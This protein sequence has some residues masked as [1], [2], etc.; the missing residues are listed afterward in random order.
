MEDTLKLEVQL[1]LG[2]KIKTRGD[3]Q[4]LSDLIVEE[5][6]TQISYNTLRR[7]FKVD[8]QAQNKASVQTLNALAK[9]IGFPTFFAF[10]ANAPVKISWGIQN[11]LFRAFDEATPEGLLNFL[12]LTRIRNPSNFIEILTT[13]IRELIL[14]KEISIVIKI[15]RSKEL[16]LMELP[17]SDRIHFGRGVGLLFRKVHF[18]IKELKILAENQVFLEMVFLIFV[19]YTSL[20]MSNGNYLRLIQLSTSGQIKLKKKDAL[21]FFCLNYFRN[22]LIQKEN[23][24][25][26]LKPTNNMH[27]ILWSRI[28]SVQLYECVRKKQNNHKLLDGITEKLSSGIQNRMDYLFE[29]MTCSLIL[30]DFNLMAFILEGNSLP[31]REIYQESHSQHM[32]IVEIFILLKQGEL[33]VLKNR[34]DKINKKIWGASYYGMYEMFHTIILYHISKS[35]TTRKRAL[36][37][38]LTRAKAMGFP[39]FSRK[40]LM[41]YFKT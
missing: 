11:E 33:K 41:N 5:Q 32:L 2:R 1:K 7:F 39:F 4:L 40:F 24:A 21:F 37:F 30:K 6:R 34:I 3:C 9:Y 22:I 36:T 15:F 26:T 29:I 13:S 25:L 8:K 12:I 27:P 16:Q 28:T 10:S 35:D 20:N 38:Y 14:T 17:Y 23:K 18:S 19:D 31:A